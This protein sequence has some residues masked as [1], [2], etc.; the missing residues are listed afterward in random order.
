MTALSSPVRLSTIPRRQRAAVTVA[1]GLSAGAVG[2]S[3]LAQA[4]SEETASQVLLL[5]EHYELMD[6]GVVVFKLETGE[7]LSLN[8]DQYLILDDGL[9]LV[10][11]ELAQASVYSL[12]VMGAVRAQLM[13]DVQP[14]RS[15]DGSVVLASDDS[16]LWSG[17]GPPPR[18]FE[19][20]ELQRHQIAQK[21]ECEVA[22]DDYSCALP[23]KAASEANGGLALGVS[24]A[25]AAIVLLSI[26]MAG[27]EPEVEQ[28]EEE[29]EAATEG[30]PE[31]QWETE[32]WKMFDLNTLPGES[33]SEPRYFAEFEGSLYF[34]ADETTEDSELW[35]FDGTTASLVADIYA[36]DTSSEPGPIVEYDDGTG[37]ALYFVAN[38]GIEGRELFKFDGS[39]VTRVTNLNTNNSV[40][41]GDSFLKFALDWYQDE[42]PA[43]YQGSLYFAANGND[44]NGTELW[45]YDGTSAT[46][47]ADIN[48]GDENSWSN[49]KGLT[50]FNGEL[51]FY[52]DDGTDGFELWKFDGASASQVAD[53]YDGS[54]DS[55]P[56]NEEVKMAVYNSTLYFSADGNDG[57]GLEL[58]QY[59]RTSASRIADINVGAGDSEPED[60]LVADGLLFFEADDGV[61]GEEMWQFD[62]TTASMVVDAV[63]GLSGSNPSRHAVVQDKVWVETTDDTYD[64]ALFYLDS[65][66]LNYFHHIG[67]PFDGDIDAIGGFDRYIV[68]QAETQ[69]AGDELWV[70]DPN[71]WP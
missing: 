18:L 23:A 35:K 24:T 62:G 19:Q 59:D 60:F 64:D 54:S 51:Y 65:T 17:D 49:P 14:V 43:V 48:A 46:L 33:D 61:H 27:D 40:N 22:S 4:A 58:W 66:G 67:D 37:S 53:I 31:A 13:S 29:T 42:R 10:T 11:D 15:P 70:Y 55:Y 68:V 30:P 5:P 25:P 8:S 12:P 6:N 9:L 41:G 57:A 44:G 7:T 20:V 28:V 69:S 34:S 3:G 56:L 45:K 39:D 2:W 26:L 21:T 63:T 16:P 52:A 47:A 36:G 50:V 32:Y 71:G 38:D 1:L